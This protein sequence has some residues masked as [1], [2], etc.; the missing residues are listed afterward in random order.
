[1]ALAAGLFSTAA[2][3]AVVLSQAPPAVTRHPV[4]ILDTAELGSSTLGSRI[5][6]AGETLPRGTTA[7][8]VWLEAVI[9]PHVS[10]DAIS[11]AHLVTRGARDAGWT[12]GSVTIP[13]NRVTR[14]WS[15]VTVCVD[16]AQS[17][18]LVGMQI[19][20]T[21]P[22][23]AATDRQGPL[24]GRTPTYRN[25]P[26]PG[27]ILVEYLQPGHASWWSLAASV[28]RRMGLGHAFSGPAVPLLAVA[29]ML[30]V[31]IATARAILE[32][33]A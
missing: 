26:L 9:G 4:P 31:A 32:E 24:P 8:R 2:A 10:A 19:A 12:A 13:V 28:A 27:R 18:E 16:V 20:R 11:D 21:A 30:L 1:M 5:C 22:G 14:R 7:I 33:L 29:L 3:V 25:G 17:R 23:V 6:Q 15:N